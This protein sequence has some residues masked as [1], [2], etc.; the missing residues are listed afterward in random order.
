MDLF[1]FLNLE[2]FFF[3]VILVSLLGIGVYVGIRKLLKAQSV[4]E[5][6]KQ[7]KLCIAL[8]LEAKYIIEEHIYHVME[9]VNKMTTD[10]YT[11]FEAYGSYDARRQHQI[12]LNHTVTNSFR[13]IER[14]RAVAGIKIDYKR[15]RRIPIVMPSY[16][17]LRLEAHYVKA[18]VKV[19]LDMKTLNKRK[20]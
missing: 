20:I 4:A 19:Y 6:Q 10:F 18:I 15:A 2:G 9:F 14:L 13:H 8:K 17:L 12:L 3:A 5:R 1:G 16:D 11:N 7:R